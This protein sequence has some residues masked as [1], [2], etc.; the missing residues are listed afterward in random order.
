MPGQAPHHVAVQAHERIVIDKATGM[1]CLIMTSAA[2]ALGYCASA[3]P[4][5]INQTTSKASC[6]ASSSRQSSIN[7]KVMPPWWH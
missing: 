1:A 7:L 4:L 3:V 2:L 5:L 6:V